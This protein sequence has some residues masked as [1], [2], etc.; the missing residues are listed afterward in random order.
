MRIRFF[1][2]GFLLLTGIVGLHAQQ[3]S[4][5]QAAQTAKDFL[6][7]K[8]PSKAR[9]LSSSLK[10]AYTS[11][12]EGKHCYYVFNRGEN[13]GFVIVSGDER[14]SGA[15]LGYSDKG[16]FDYSKLPINAKGWMDA[17][18]NEIKNLKSQAIPHTRANAVVEPLLGETAWG[19]FAPYNDMIPE[20]DGEHCPV[21]CEN[22]AL[23]QIMYYHRW[24]EHGTQSVSYTWYGGLT[25]RGELSAD[26]TQ[27]TYRWDLMTPTYDENS[28]Q[29]SREAVALLMRDVSYASR[30]QFMADAS[31]GCARPHPLYDYFDYDKSAFT[32]QRDYMTTDQWETILREELDAGRPMRYRGGNHSFVCDGYNADGYFHFNYGWD[33]ISNGWYLSSATGFDTNQEVDV[34]IKKNEGGKLSIAFGSK[35]NFMHTS[36]NKVSYNLCYFSCTS[37][38]EYDL[39]LAI[40]IEN[41]STHEMKYLSLPVEMSHDAQGYEVFEGEQEINTELAD[42][43]YVLYPVF[44]SGDEPWRKVYFTEKLQTEVDLKVRNGVK[45]FANNGLYME[46]ENG[47]VEVDGICYLLDDETGSATVTYRNNLMNSYSGDVVIPETITA[48]GK[49]YVVNALGELAFSECTMTS[50]VIPKTVELIGARCFEISFVDRIT[51]EK[52]SKL[53]TIDHC[54]FSPCEVK[55]PVVLPDGLTEIL[56]SAFANF[57]APDLTI[58]G[59]VKTIGGESTFWSYCDIYRVSWQ[60]P[61]V[62]EANTFHINYD[63]IDYGPLYPHV[64]KCTL[65]VPF[66]TTE[67][68][69]QATDFK[70]FG[71]IIESAQ[72]EEQGVLVNVYEDNT[73]SVERTNEI[74]EGEVVIPSATTYGE[75]EYTVTAIAPSSFEDQDLLTAVSIPETITSIGKKAFAGCALLNSIRSASKVPPTLGTVIGNEETPSASRSRGISQ[76]NA[77]S[78]F[79]GVNLSNCTLY[80]PEGCAEAYRSAPGW[81]NFT[82]IQE[83]STMV[84]ANSYTIEYGDDLPQYE[85]TSDVKELGGTPEITCTAT[86]TSSPGTYPIVIAK[87]TV[88]NEEITYANGT[89]MIKKA[90]LKIKVGTYTKQQGEENPEFEVAYEGFKNNETSAVLLVKPSVNTLA[91][92]DSPEGEYAVTA[93]GALSENYEIT[94]SAGKLI[95]TAEVIPDNTS[96]KISAAKQVPY[97]S[98]YNLDFTDLPDLKAYVATGYEKATGT[99]WLTRVMQVPAETGFLLIGD[100]GDYDIPTID[101]VSDVYYKN[102]FKGTLTG[103]TIYTTE[104]EYTNYY[105]SKGTSGVGFYKVTNEN[106]QKIGANR[107]Y[108]P[109]LT[110]IPANGAEGDAEVIKVSAA[111]QVP[112]YTS[113]NID[114]STLDAQGVKAYT[115]TGYNYGSGVIWLTRVKKV[116]AQ[117]GILV[118]AEKE[119]EYSVPT[120]SVQSVYENMFTG[121]ETA[122][123]IYTTEEIDGITYINYYLSNGESGVGF[124]KVTKE[125]GVKMGANRSYLQIPKRDTA[126]GARGMGNTTSTFS[127]LVIS[128]N[129]DDVIAIPLFSGDATSISDVQQRVGEKDVYYNLQ[130]QRVEKPSKG[131][132]IRNGK[133]VVIK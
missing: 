36:G 84:K 16:S 121:S 34:K 83:Y 110:D 106:G 103:T 92:K 17:Y 5:E 85:F 64:E 8:A 50:L 125:D 7:K 119:G 107:C 73:A 93:N 25:V 63:N 108:L 19:Q 109:I 115:A 127:K 81:E 111:K 13:D 131:L 88:T 65:Y 26:L 46:V 105:L 101:G 76:E 11:T 133:K 89:L 116:P 86:K 72:Q 80:V 27:S 52:G 99:I 75:D 1:L 4:E 57:R 6:S 112:Y 70:H 41:T 51:F 114:F 31:Y 120:T 128:D 43:D 35:R 126:A 38:L 102:M 37:Y 55:Y 42:G 39:S 20:I 10:L 48:N 58:P 30:S 47:A 78:V 32:L 74:C 118:M 18:S 61:P 90:P 3:V 113:K 21:G 9:G 100:P 68:Y 124:Y 62:L 67:K 130:G 53:K 87:G 82:N 28:S 95:V 96:I 60:E 29:E 122:Q 59:S 40:A 123:T 69:R 98:K 2:T 54:A 129:D 79:E 44:A 117:T 23:A 24:P 71:T 97:C 91:T 56:E 66:G 49:E 33:G 15:V 132:F 12:V 77:E 104:G 14:T 22:T 94:Y 45:A